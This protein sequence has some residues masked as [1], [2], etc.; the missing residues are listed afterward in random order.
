MHVL[1]DDCALIELANGGI[2]VGFKQRVA[3]DQQHRRWMQCRCS[4]QRENGI[5]R[6]EQ[7]GI[8]QDRPARSE[9]AV[10]HAPLRTVHSDPSIRSRRRGC[11]DVPAELAAGAAVGGVLRAGEDALDVGQELRNAGKVADAVKDTAE[12]AAT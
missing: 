9:P 12:E 4:V 8:Q 3:Q 7:S 11:D 10:C 5:A 6:G 1:A 2:D